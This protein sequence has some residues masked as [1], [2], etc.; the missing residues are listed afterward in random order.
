FTM[1]RAPGIGEALFAHSYKERADERMT[2]AFHDPDVVTEEFVADVTSM[3]ERPGTVAAA[4]A[5]VRGMRF[6]EVEARY[7]TIAQPTLLLWGR[8][9]VVTP[10]T[11]GE[12][13]ANELPSARLVVYPRCG[14]FPMIE[15]RAAS[16]ADL[17]AFLAS[18]HAPPA[19]PSPPPSASSASTSSGPAPVPAPAPL[20][21]A[22]PVGSEASRGPSSKEAP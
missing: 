14:H 4:L 13:L 6:A 9:D 1:A 18:T 10:V 12:R 5:A 7:R 2:L 3:L 11:V 19:P 8:D 17:L 20:P 22:E 21:S 16:N 15:A